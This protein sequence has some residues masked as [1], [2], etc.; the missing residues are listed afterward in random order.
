VIY[1]P[2]GNAYC[3]DFMF[4]LLSLQFPTIIV[5]SYRS[6]TH[7]RKTNLIL[8]IYT[9][10]PWVITYLGV[11]VSCLLGSGTNVILSVLGRRLFVAGILRQGEDTAMLE[12]LGSLLGTCS[13]PVYS[14]H[15]ATAGDITWSWP[16]QHRRLISNYLLVKHTH[17][18][19]LTTWKNLISM[20]T[21]SK[22]QGL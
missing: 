3:N 1:R 8:C 17:N 4:F 9:K 14:L 12:H 10:L 16:N 19:L 22:I 11:P 7:C 21:P 6:W 13:P 2:I 5:G 20:M 15:C 18:L